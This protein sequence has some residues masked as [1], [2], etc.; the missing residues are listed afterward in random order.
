MPDRIVLLRGGA[1]DG[2]STTVAEEVTRLLVASEAPGLVDVYEDSGQHA[3]VRGNDEPGA[4]FSWVGQEPLD[5]EHG[6][7]LRM[8]HTGTGGA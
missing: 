2:A 1:R 4:V 3:H 5:A 7:L 6:Q 8:P